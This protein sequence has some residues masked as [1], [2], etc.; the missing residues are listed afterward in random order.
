M[1]E[2]WIYSV[3][4]IDIKLELEDLKDIKYCIVKIVMWF[5]YLENVFFVWVLFEY[6]L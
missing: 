2:D 4:M 1:Y 3:G 6:I 5:E